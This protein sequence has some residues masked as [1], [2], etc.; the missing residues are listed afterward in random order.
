MGGDLAAPKRRKEGTDPF[1]EEGAGLIGG[2]GAS[3]QIRRENDVFSRGSCQQK[4]VRKSGLVSE[5]RSRLVV[6]GR[7]DEEL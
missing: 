6:G 1:R 5:K 4:P 3:E 7:G 2:K